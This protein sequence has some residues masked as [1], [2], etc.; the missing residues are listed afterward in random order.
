MKHFMGLA[1]LSLFIALIQGCATDPFTGTWVAE[2][3]DGE[4]I[5]PNEGIFEL[6]FVDDKTVRGIEGDEPF[7]MAYQLR[8]PN[9]L[10]FETGVEHYWR[11]D[12]SGKLVTISEDISVVWNRK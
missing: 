11:I 9:V 2:T 6:S 3:I 8:D 1:V 5:P 10:V 7:V 4:P 12:Q